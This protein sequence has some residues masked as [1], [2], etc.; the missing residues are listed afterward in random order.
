MAA[1]QSGNSTKPNIHHETR[2]CLQ[3]D[4]LFFYAN[5]Q[6]GGFDAKAKRTFITNAIL[7]GI[8]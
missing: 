5:F 4:T 8:S 1:G 2:Y 3:N 6:K 7:A